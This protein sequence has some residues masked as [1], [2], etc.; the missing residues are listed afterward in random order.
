MQ[1]IHKSLKEILKESMKARDL[2]RLEVVRYLLTSFVN[3]LVSKNRTPQDF[4]ND[5]EAVNVIRR[6]IKQREDSISQYE[7]ANRMDLA[8]EDKAQLAV[9]LTFVPAQAGEDDIL[10]KLNEIKSS[11]PDLDKSK[12]GIIIGMVKKE[13]ENNADGALIKKVVENNL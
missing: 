8:D 5:E 13:F 10:K 3:E 12:I 2:V 4:L 7:S 11:N 6:I 9:M 1:D